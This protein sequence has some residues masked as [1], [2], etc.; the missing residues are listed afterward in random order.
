MVYKFE[1]A[2][3]V[4]KGICNF[5]KMMSMPV[6]KEDSVCSVVTLSI[7]MLLLKSLNFVWLQ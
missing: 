4:A 7:G 6:L 3:L 5:S 1:N 2:H